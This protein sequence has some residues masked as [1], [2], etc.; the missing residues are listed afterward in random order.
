[1]PWRHVAQAQLWAGEG[2][3]SWKEG[4]VKGHPWISKGGGQESWVPSQALL[5]TR[6]MAWPPFPQ[7][8]KDGLDI[9]E[10]F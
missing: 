4:R 5:Q 10:S 6:R 7:P 3:G 2:P 1:M 8:S 9:L